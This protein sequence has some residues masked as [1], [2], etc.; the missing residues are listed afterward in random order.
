MERIPESIILPNEQKVKLFLAISGSDGCAAAFSET[1]N[2]HIRKLHS[3]PPTPAAGCRFLQNGRK[4]CRKD[5]R[6]LSEPWLRRQAPGGDARMDYGALLSKEICPAE[7]I[8]G[9]LNLAAV[10]L[11]IRVREWNMK[12]LRIGNQLYGA[13]FGLFCPVNRRNDSQHLPI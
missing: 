1:V 12:R 11:K 8:P 4:L 2:T 7:P 9:N 3:K 10:F 6:G 13:E 5:A